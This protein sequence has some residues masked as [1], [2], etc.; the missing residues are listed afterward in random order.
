MK[1]KIYKKTVKNAAETRETV[2][3]DENGG[4]TDESRALFCLVRYFDRSGRLKTNQWKR[5]KDIDT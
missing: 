4:F 5:L 1:A 2:Y 3:F